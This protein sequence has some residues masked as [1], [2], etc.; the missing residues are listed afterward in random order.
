MIRTI[1]FD[2]DDTLYPRQVGIMEQIRA[3]MLRYM[4]T[5]FNLSPEEADAL[6]R[7]YFLTYGTT[8]RGLQIHHHIDPNE[9]L[10][11]VHDVP[12]HEFLQPN[13]ELR[14]VLDAI[15]LQKVIFT[16][17]SREHAER[18]LDLLGVRHQ[19][20]QIIDVR[21]LN[22]ESKPQ[23]AA[24]HRICQLLDVRPEECLLVEDN[25][26]NLRPAKALGMTTVLVKDGSGELAE[27]VDYVIHR[28]EDIAQVLAEIAPP[29]SLGQPRGSRQS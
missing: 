20:S 10:D 12:L 7:Q 28:V 29:N 4:Q 17:A 2:L 15:P 16:N 26:S 5:R 1:L 3:L 22:F 23:P 19:F 25:V 11:F 21:D 18:V 9:F 27:N 24:Y 13:A 14:Q 8:M 6:R